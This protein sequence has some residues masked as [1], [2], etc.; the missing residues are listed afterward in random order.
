MNLPVKGR[1]TF[2]SDF[3][4]FFSP[5][6]GRARNMSA[7][8]GPRVFLVQKRYVLLLFYSVIFFPANPKLRRGILQNGVL[9]AEL[10]SPI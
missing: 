4:E 7:A 2:L 9:N 8:L 10:D 1:T 5:E 6:Y 3:I